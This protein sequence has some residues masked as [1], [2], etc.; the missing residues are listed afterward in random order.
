[1]TLKIHLLGEDPR[2]E[3]GLVPTEGKEVLMTMMKPFSRGKAAETGYKNHKVGGAQDHPLP[4]RTTGTA[5]RGSPRN[6]TKVIASTDEAKI[7]AKYLLQQRKTVA[8]KGRE[9]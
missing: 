2:T 1:M 8:M 4:R 9:L 3:P 5:V 7:R 6:M